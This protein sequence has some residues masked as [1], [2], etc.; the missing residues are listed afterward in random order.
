MA[1]ILDPENKIDLVKMMN[2]FK[3]H[4]P[5]YARPIFI[6]VLSKVDMTG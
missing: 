3:T 4:L 6:R 2:G 1:A 5:S